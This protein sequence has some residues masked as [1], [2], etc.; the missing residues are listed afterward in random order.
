MGL[1]LDTD[2]FGGSYNLIQRFAGF[3]CS[4]YM[5][6]QGATFNIQNTQ[7]TTSFEIVQL[8]IKEIVCSADLSCNGATFIINDNVNIERIVCAV[9]ACDQC[10]VKNSAASIGTPCYQY[11]VVTPIGPIVGPPVISVDPPIIL[12]QST[13]STPIQPFSTIPATS[14]TSTTSTSSSTLSPEYLSFFV[15]SSTSSTT[16][17]ST[18]NNVNPNIPIPPQ[19]IP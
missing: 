2:L 9:G 3:L 12:Q 13:T 14:T 7:K 4:G 10:L 19:F 11:S 5:G 16:T 8:D 18:T 17:T 15:T 6:C 1:N